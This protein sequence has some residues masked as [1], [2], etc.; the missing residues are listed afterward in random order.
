MELIES[1]VRAFS[2]LPGIGPKNARRI[3]YHLLRA[4][5]EVGHR[6]ASTLVRM[7]DDVVRCSVCNNFTDIDP[8]HIC[9]D[10]SRS[11]ETICVVSLPQ[12]TDTVE[13]SGE[14]RGKYHVLGGEISPLDGV[15]PGDLTLAQLR[16]RVE[17]GS[18][19]EVIVATNATVEG[20]TTAVYV[21]QL[22]TDLNVRV[23]RPAFGLPV[24]GDLEYADRLTL[25]RSLRGRLPVIRE[26]DADLS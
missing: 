9:T 2:R 5:K 16:R 21:A 8:C 20:D 23:T 22:L 11:D 12:D 7:V 17:S 15:G 25:T 1:T 26:D 3:A 10:P 19:R 6:L 4:D 18:V 24:G 13:Q 14:F